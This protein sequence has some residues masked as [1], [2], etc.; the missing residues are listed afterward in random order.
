MRKVIVICL[1]FLALPVKSQLLW[2][3]THP[4]TKKVSFLFGTMHLANYRYFDAHPAPFD[5]LKKCSR[6]ITEVDLSDRG[7]MF[8]MFRFAAMP[9]GVKLSDSLS[10]NQW[11]KL[12]SML[13]QGE[14]PVHASV[15]DDYR[16]AL[17]ES[18][19]S[20]RMFADAYKD[21]VYERMVPIDQGI[22]D[23]AY[24]NGYRRDFLETPEDQFTVMFVKPSLALQFRSLKRLIDGNEDSATQVYIRRSLKLPEYYE[25]QQMD[26]M[27]LVIDQSITG[28]A[29]EAA[30][31]KQLLTER[32]NI[33]LKKLEGQ[34]E[35]ERCF[36][37][38]GAAHLMKEDGLVAG[39][40]RMGY[41]VVP[42]RYP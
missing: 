38:V 40:R 19:L 11:H 35:K 4:V 7:A 9:D 34:F 12:D 39:L 1:L 2:R 6:I 26:S 28:D 31:T 27:E 24:K 18:V 41:K 8:S 17:V 3:V 23:Y 14:P 30:W 5:S 37:A 21:L 29:E 20:A 25:K 22:A 36:L 32:N 33:W 15:Y 42:V 16:P 13:Q 10:K